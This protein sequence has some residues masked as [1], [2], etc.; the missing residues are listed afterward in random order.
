MEIE[1]SRILSTFEDESKGAESSFT[2]DSEDQKINLKQDIWSSLPRDAMESV[3]LR[4]PIRSLMRVRAVC[5][6]WNSAITSEGF[7]D[8]YSRI[9]NRNPWLLI[10]PQN[11]GSVGLAYD[12]SSQN[13]FEIPLSFLPF[14]SRVVATAEGMFCLVPKASL[15]KVWIVCNPISRSWREL[16]SP[17][18]IFKLF[19]VLVGILVDE[20]AKSFKIV[21]AGSK[22]VAED[23]EQF[24]LTTEVYD[25]SLRCWRK[26]GSILLDAPLSPWKAMSGGILY[27]VTSSLPYRVLA[28][29]V[30]G[31][32]WFELK[33]PMPENLSLARLVDHG[34]Q[35][36]MVG[37]IGHYGVT[38]EIGI[39]KLNSTGAVWKEVGWMPRPYRNDLLNSLSRRFMCIGQGN[40]LYFSNKKC[41]G[42]LQHNLIAK[43]WQWIPLSPSIVNFHYYM[44]RGFYFQPRLHTWLH[45][46]L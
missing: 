41:Q 19:F 28:Y 27:C 23:S 9:P 45:W 6:E 12:A 33:A 46:Q 7:T 20:D 35:L 43:S 10:F 25:S 1:S 40:L 31:A 44:L 17:P 13:W 8:L 34:D 11:D 21:R 38:S 39:W 14:E 15:R 37:G 42:V 16:P 30:K 26:G 2:M 18:S 22:L 5:K 36:L 32:Y 24:I 4:L 29:D 3:I